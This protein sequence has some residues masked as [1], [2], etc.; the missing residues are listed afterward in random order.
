MV[1]WLFA[2][3]ASGAQ[4]SQAQIPGTNLAPVIEPH[5]GGM[6]HKIEEDWHGSQLSDNLPQ[7]KRERLG[8]DQ[9][10]SSSQKKNKIK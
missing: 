1:Q 9:G 5:C 7:V 10:Q 3:S 6:P 2:C 4:G 8:T